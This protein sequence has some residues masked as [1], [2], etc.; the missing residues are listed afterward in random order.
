MAED[1]KIKPTQM[2]FIASNSKLEGQAHEYKEMQ[3]HI[4][5]TSKTKT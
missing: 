2:Q 5:I 1:I 4:Y 3:Y